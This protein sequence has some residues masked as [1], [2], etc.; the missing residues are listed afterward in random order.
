[1]SRWPSTSHVE[2]Q[3]YEKY[4]RSRSAYLRLGTVPSFDLTVD[5]LDD[6]L[7]GE[8]DPIIKQLKADRKELIEA[9]KAKMA[10]DATD[11][12]LGASHVVSQPYADPAFDGLTCL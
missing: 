8:G 5:Q 4:F 10:A 3:D 2:V 11:F 6:E 12:P 1:M 7:G 9:L